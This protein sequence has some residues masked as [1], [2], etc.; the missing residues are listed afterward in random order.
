M[1]L[2]ERYFERRQ[3]RE[4]IAFAETGGVAI[5][6][7][8]DHYSGRLSFRGMTMTAPFLHVLGLRPVL[9][10][11]A[12]RH[13]IPVQAIQPEKRRRVAHIDVWGEFAE[14]LIARVVTSS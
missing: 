12:A 5:H 3:I 6:R 7:N 11:W 8:F 14:Q 1:E 9:T 10:I 4:A 2:C 13:G